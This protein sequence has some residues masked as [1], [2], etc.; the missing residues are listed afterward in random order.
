MVIYVRIL[1]ENIQ[2]LTK[3]I[4]RVLKNNFITLF[5]VEE[6][7]TAISDTYLQYS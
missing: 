7:S 6:I 1:I 4:N 5:Y 3:I 2:K